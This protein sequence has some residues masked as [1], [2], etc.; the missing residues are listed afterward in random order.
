MMNY[1]TA[2]ESHGPQLTGII[3]GI[4]S[5]LH[6]DVDAINDQLKKRQGGYG[7]GNRQKI[8]HDE[9][10][11]T[12]GV[13]HG[14]T[15]GSPIALV[16]NNRDHAHWSQIMDPVSPETPENTLR[17]VERPRPGHADL[18]GGIK[19]RHGDLRNVLERSSARETAI[20]VAIGAVCKQ[21]LQQ[22]GIDIVGYVEQI[23]Q[24]STDEN[25]ELNV[26]KIE[27]EISQNDLRIIDQTKVSPIHDL[28]DQ[29]KRDG[30]TLGGIIRV[31]ATNVPAGLG[32]YISWDTKL[33]GKLAA[34]VMGVNAMKGVEIGDGFKAATSFGSQV[35]DEIDWNQDQGF[36]RNTD[37]LGGFEGGM[38]NGMP[39]IVKAAMKPIPTLYKPLQSVDIQTKEVKKANVERS[40]TTAIV[41]A[42]I[43]IESVVAIELAKAL[44]DKFDGDN[45]QR[46]QEQLDQYRDELKKF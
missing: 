34:A 32:S 38:T 18:V 14:I 35:M 43:V 21:F 10:T 24:I 42:S 4:P 5:G 45:L 46:L 37:H 9:V 16:V 6:L 11:I 17:K 26:A 28:I 7:R 44:T 19:Y 12:G 27:A 41:P 23:G 13:R 39:I 29:T 36:F 2:G 20:R 40:D 22:L 3:E 31:V 25:P 33:D 30:D 1:L 15:L 8:E